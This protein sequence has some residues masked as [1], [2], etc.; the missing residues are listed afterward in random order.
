MVAVAAESPCD[1]AGVGIDGEG[2]V[3]CEG[4]GGKKQ[5]ACDQSGT[6]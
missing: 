1:L 4:A 6:D 3:L 5:H 2:L